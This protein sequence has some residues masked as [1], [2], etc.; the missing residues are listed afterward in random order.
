[1]KRLK[2]FLIATSAIVALILVSCAPLPLI[3]PSITQNIVEVTAN[4]ADPYLSD[5]AD[6][7]D[8]NDILML[9]YELDQPPDGFDGRNTAF[10]GSPAAE[11]NVY[12]NNEFVGNYGTTDLNTIKSTINASK[13]TFS[14]TLILYLKADDL[15]GTSWDLIVG[16]AGQTKIAVTNYVL[17][18][19]Q[20]E[21]SIYKVTK[22]QVVS[23]WQNFNVPKDMSS[24][25]N[26]GF[27]FF[28]IDDDRVVDARV[29]Y[30]Q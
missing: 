1:M 25:T 29:I 15:L 2:W 22:V 19:F 20:T 4:S 18:E 30:P 14:G 11:E 21:G 6:W 8:Q 23:D 17:V 5:L 12:L 24:I 16:E 9:W 26:K 28:R 13:T 10:S 3:I 27:A 7:C